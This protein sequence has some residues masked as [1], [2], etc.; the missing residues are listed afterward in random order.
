MSSTKSFRDQHDALLKMAGELGRALGAG[1]VN[2]A[3]TE[4]VKLLA[5]FS[6]KLN[7]HLAMEDKVLYPRLLGCRD[8]GTQALA[9]KGQSDMGGI[10]AAFKT[11]RTRWSNAHR[12]EADQPGF[13]RE[14]RELLAVLGGR[15]TWENDCLYAAADAL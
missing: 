14:T 9:R 4:I 5:M 2:R 10:A 11:Y 8:A 7:V 12:I 15:I 3:P 13:V 1:R 6:G